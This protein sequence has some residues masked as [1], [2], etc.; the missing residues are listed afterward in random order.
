MTVPM[1]DRFWAKVSRLGPVDCWLWGASCRRGYGRFGNASAHRV[2]YELLVGPI[3]P[4]MLLDHACHTADPDCP[5]GVCLHRRCVNPAHL[6][7][8]PNRVNVLRGRG[9]AA[10]AAAKT[11]CVRGHPFDEVNTRHRPDG[12]RACRSCERERRGVHLVPASERTHCPLGHPYDEANTYL[13]PQGHR[14]CRVCHRARQQSR[15]ARVK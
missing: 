2:A 9:L 5:G 1:E 8:V 10:K 13:T 3:P 4:G 6:E 14:H 15:R 7:P 11:S 12:A